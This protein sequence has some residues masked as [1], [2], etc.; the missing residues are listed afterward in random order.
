MEKL[1][2][3][4]DDETIRFGFK[5]YLEQEGFDIYQSGTVKEALEKFSKNQ[6][7]LVLLDLNLPDGFGFD[8]YK[9]MKALKY[10]P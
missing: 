1:S 6:L 7:N 4:E 8:L 5:Y 3:V 2:I 10:V 9:S